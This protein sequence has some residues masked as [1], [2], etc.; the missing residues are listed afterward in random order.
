MTAP[1]PRPADLPAVLDT[2]AGP[3]RRV[4]AAG[5]APVMRVHDARARALA[6][7]GLGQWRTTDRIALRDR[8][9]TVAGDGGLFALGDPAAPTAFIAL[10]EQNPV[11]RDT[12]PAHDETAWVVEQLTSDPGASGAAGALLAAVETAATEAGVGLLRMDCQDDLVA[13]RRWWQT[14]D[15]RPVDTCVLRG[16]RRLRHEKRLNPLPIAGLRADRLPDD[17]LEGEEFPH[18]EPATL[19]FVVERGRVLLIHKQRGHG[20]GRINGPGGKLEFGET[21]LECAVRETEEEVC[22]RVREPR[23]AGELRFLDTDGS[24]IHGF[25]FT[26]TAYDGE[27]GPTAEAV[28]EWFDVNA[29]PYERMWPDDR[30]WLPW[31]LAGERFRAAF[32]THEEGIEAGMLRLG[33]S[34][35]GP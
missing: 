25:V 17:V 29:I 3:A 26:A 9:V 14:R 35:K 28:P 27:P 7:R 10:V 19:M 2:D 13:L 6:V 32:L 23:Y 20:A 16:A 8:L 34:R 4:E 24:R 18:G 5:L 21:P 22:I 31:V 33:E 12:P 1:R 30:M 15:Y 11:W